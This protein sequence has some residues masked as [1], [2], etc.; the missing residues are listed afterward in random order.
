MKFKLI[1]IFLAL[2]IVTNVVYADTQITPDSD[3]Y[4][5]KVYYYQNNNFEA[6]ET[7]TYIFW[8]TEV[9]NYG[10]T[11]TIE[12]D[13]INSLR[14]THITVED[15]EGNI[16]LDEDVDYTGGGSCL[17]EMFTT[18]RQLHTI[19][20]T[21]EKTA[22]PPTT[23]YYKFQIYESGESSPPSGNSGGG[24]GG[25]A[26]GR[27]DNN[28]GGWKPFDCSSLPPILKDFCEWVNNNIGGAVQAITGFQKWLED[29]FTAFWQGLANIAMIPINAISN[30][31]NWVVTGV[32]NFFTGIQKAICN[33]ATAVGNFFG[34]IPKAIGDF[35]GSLWKSIQDGFS[36]LGIQVG[37]VTKPLQ[38]NA[39]LIIAIILIAIGIFVFQPALYLGVIL[40][41]FWGLQQ[42]DIVKNLLNEPKYFVMIIFGLA[43]L[44]L[45]L[46]R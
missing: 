32:T 18:K 19:R 23:Y 38:D 30:F 3:I 14:L 45:L 34:G 20:F 39:I 40:L 15:D 9:S 4:P 10:V 17:I 31:C 13:D 21:F 28:N 35:F 41:G 43:G 1:L 46:K 33:Y 25:G 24:G 36:W 7:H 27:G 2:I 22:E 26:G 16:L 5:D 29:T 11:W 6:T 12:F 37:N 8:A 42:L 44:A